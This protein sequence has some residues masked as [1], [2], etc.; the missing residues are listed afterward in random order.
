MKTIVL[1]ALLFAVACAFPANEVSENQVDQAV[2][3]N[4]D[5]VEP[6]VADGLNVDRVKRHG[7]E[8]FKVMKSA[9]IL[10]FKS[11]QRFFF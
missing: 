10:N 1:F 11:P 3:L 8:K 4:F 7:N 9:E 6:S 2:E 5:D